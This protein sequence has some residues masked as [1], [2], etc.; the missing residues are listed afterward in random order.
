MSFK[1]VNARQREMDRLIKYA[2]GMNAQVVIRRHDPKIKHFAE[3]ELFSDNSVRITIFRRPRMSD[4][5]LVLTMIHELGHHRDFIALHRRDIGEPSVIRDMPK[6]ERKKVYDYELRGMKYWKQI[7]H[8]TD[9]TFPIWRLF[10]QM[11]IDINAYEYF[12]LHAQDMPEKVRRACRKEI[13]AR[14][15][16]GYE[17]EDTSVGV[18]NEETDLVDETADDDNNDGKG[19]IDE[20]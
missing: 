17:L 1:P 15:K 8:D 2:H 16:S 9:C 5:E 4:L 7:Y 11:E 14:H 19:E 3:W 12:Y 10:M 20:T 18:W 6:A 13:T